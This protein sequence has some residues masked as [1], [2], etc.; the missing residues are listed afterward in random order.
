MYTTLFKSIL[1]FFVVNTTKN[2]K[3]KYLEKKNAELLKV[4]L[5]TR[6]I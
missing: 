6:V 5:E 1:S 4:N 3:V 2:L